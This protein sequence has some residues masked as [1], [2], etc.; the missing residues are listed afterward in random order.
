MGTGQRVGEPVCA[1]AV[2]DPLQW[3]TAAKSAG[4][5]GGIAVIK[6]HDGFCLWPTSTTKHN[7]TSSSNANAKETNVPRDF[8]AAAKKLGMKYG[9]Y[10]SPWDR[11]SPYWAEKDDDG[12]YTST[13]TNDVFFK[14]CGE[15]A[16][17]GD[18]QFEMWFDGAR[19]GSGHYGGKGGK[20]IVPLNGN[21]ANSYDA[22]VKA[23][24][25]RITINDAK[26]C[27]LLH[28]VSIY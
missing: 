4:M 5:Q 3:L 6:H 13:Y 22:G 1:T 26:A 27:P 12:N 7:V 11:N 25:V 24:A 9:F 28:T 15:A 10:I 20:R 8:A 21:T 23:K 18:D 2:P 19:G 16:T 14:Q 17:Y